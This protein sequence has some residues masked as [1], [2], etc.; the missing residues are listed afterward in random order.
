MDKYKPILIDANEIITTMVMDEKTKTGTLI[1]MPIAD[2]LD[3]WTVEGCP[4]PVEAEPIKHGRWIEIGHPWYECSECGE[5]TAVVN[6]NGEVV[7]NYCPNCG[8]RMD[9]KETDFYSI[10]NDGTYSA[11]D[12]DE[13]Q[14]PEDKDC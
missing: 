13:I 7:W 6:L 4:K 8:A 5:R 10:E 3:K 14:E 9:E 1:K 2:A 12:G 11:G